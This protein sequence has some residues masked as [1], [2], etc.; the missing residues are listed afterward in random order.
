MSFKSFLESN[1][2]NNKVRIFFDIETFQFNEKQGYKNPSLFKN[3]MFSFEISYFC[4]DK[5][6]TLS[7]NNFGLFLDFFEMTAPD[8]KP[9]I[10][11]IAH[12]NN[13]YDNVYLLK[14]L[15]YYYPECQEFNMYLRDSVC[16]IENTKKIKEI[17]SSKTKKA[18]H[19]GDI[20]VL[21]KR[22]KTSNN[23]EFELFFHK[24]RF[25]TIDNFIKTNLSIKS[26]GLKLQK[27]GVIEENELKTDF[28]Y[29]KYN[30]THDMTD[31]ESRIYAKEIY[32]SLNEYQKTYIKND[33]II[34]AKSVYH[35]SNIFPGFDY[36]KITFSSN[37]LDDYKVNDLTSW[38]LLHSVGEGSEKM[39]VN[40]T[41]Y[42]FGAENCYDYFKHFYKGGLN[43]Y[44]DK[45]IGK[46]I[47]SDMFSIDLNSSYPNAMY[48]CKI[49][50]ALKSFSEKPSILESFDKNCFYIFSMSKDSF[51]NQILKKISSKI[52]KQMLV[53]YYS[54][55][56]DNV[57]INSNTI[58]MLEQTL[59]EKFGGL[60]VDNYCEFTCVSFGAK[61]KIFEHYFI[62]S[63]GKL[64]NKLVMKDPRNYTITKEVNKN[65]NTSEEIYN[66]KVMLN[67]IY[68]IPALRAYF[69]LFAID[70][71]GNVNN[72]INAYKNSERN[73]IF[74]IAV[75][76]IALM[77]LIEPLK[78]LTQKEIDECLVY[79]DTDS[80]YL[81]KTCFDKIPKSFYDPI[82]L[83]SWD[84]EH[85]NIKGF[86][87]LNHK[88][89][90]YYDA[91]KKEI[92]VRSGGISKNSWNLDMSFD[93]FL[94]TQFHDGAK[95][96][97]IKSILTK[98]RTVAIYNSKTEIKKGSKYPTEF[99]NIDT[100]VLNQI[101]LSL[102]SD[103]I[104]D[105]IY[106]ETPLGSLSSSEIN[107]V[108]NKTDHL[109]PISELKK[110]EQLIIKRDL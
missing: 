94:K 57:Y 70:K 69:N 50:S 107:P 33:V 39:K 31:D 101:I 41:D 14:D 25:K 86:L 35:Y 108:K 22:V 29:I 54:N 16:D 87:A 82:S 93:D 10:E 71:N 5:L 73:I 11:L 102:K 47:T 67:G 61:R 85:A 26:L 18:R 78:Y 55:S 110:L 12:N 7:F 68:G 58:K 23:L 106:I 105:E 13:K 103:E 1:K 43:F 49:P 37:I 17:T 4:K 98:Y 42:S 97:N 34:L 45:Y 83:G 75:T 109:K 96:K 80:L 88:K 89:Y 53:K 60:K 3:C 84:V 2:N 52:I 63:Q 15:K 104:E 32:Q 20:I 92:G 100:I 95:I 46:K 44:N 90:C 62:K 6:E 19:Q 64:K 51:N 79:C 30:K 36:D 8:Y 27:L 99:R 65:I 76:S 81:K 40:Y 21:E 66:S 9:T 24:L 59:Q 48:F 56:S 74:S 38:Q 28:D 72:H 91:D 77:N